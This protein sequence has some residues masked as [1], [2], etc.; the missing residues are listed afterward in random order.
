MELARDPKY[1]IVMVEGINEP[2]TDFGS[3]H[4][5]PQVT[6]DVQ[7]YL[8][9]NRI[10][11]IP[12]LG[13]SIVYGLPVPE[14]YISPGYCSADELAYLNERMDIA[15]PHFYPPNVCDLD[16]GANRG[17]CFDDVVTGMRNTY[18][19]KPISVTE[20]Q[21][22]L[23]GVNSTDDYL[24]GYYTPWMMLSAWRLKIHSMMWYPLFDYGTH[25][26]CGFFPKD[27]NNPRPSA[28]AMRA[29]HTLAGDKGP[30]HARSNP[31]SST[32]SVEGGHGPINE[33]S[34]NSGTQHQL[35]QRS[36]GDFLLFVYNEQIEPEGD[37]R[38]VTVTFGTAPKRVTEYRDPA[39][40]QLRPAGADHLGADGASDLDAR[41]HAAAGD[42]AVMRVLDLFSGIG[43]FSLG[44]ERAGMTTAAFCE[45]D[46]YCRRV[47]AK[48]W[49][50]VPCYDDVR[51]LTAER[52]RADGISV[53]VICGGFPC[54]DI[55]VAGRGAGIS[56][57]RS[58]LWRE[59]ARIIGEVG[60]RYVLVENVAALLSRGLGDVLGDLAAFGY[61][62]EWHC[63][64][65]AA[66]GAPHRRDRIWI[67][68]DATK[69]LGNGCE[70]HR[71]HTIREV[72][73]PGNG[74]G[75]IRNAGWL[76]P[77]RHGRIVREVGQSDWWRVEPDVGRVAHGTSPELDFIGRLSDG[78]YN[79]QESIAEAAAI[80]GRL[81]RAMW[82]NREAAKTSPE[83]YAD[84]L[85][86]AVPEMPRRP[87]Y[88]RWFM[89]SWKQDD[90][91]LCGLWEAFSLSPFDQPDMQ[92]ELLQR[93]RPV[94]RQQALAFRR[95]DR[96]RGLG[97]SLVP[98]IPELIGRAILERA[99]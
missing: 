93:I 67:M 7:D 99:A 52:L 96:L 69:L 29:M 26:P 23:Y 57:E 53:D 76:P 91:G 38:E 18:G 4:V 75:E 64:P 92:Q 60:P 1:G 70:L 15:N 83:L 89:G 62:A 17:G 98:Q 32:T 41:D 30:T 40:R 48:H 35:F 61:D 49:P 50:E 74:G 73:E 63:I 94:E 42:R 11:G 22:T 6:M 68:A 25:H 65:A 90:E 33:A 51:S 54:Q 9:K 77:T 66:V 24:D 3:G 78:E 8:W 2:N 84:R 44:L 5:P 19:D 12:V 72:P 45:I 55:S 39:K 56:G 95:V 80:I 46:P 20:W 10:P 27:A 13:P 88:S 87:A 85:H 28:Y 21:P 81:L 86:C 71:E 31:A 97:N 34:P 59:F 47:L 82:C 43:A 16:P 37:E 36:N 58:G 79:D 14:G